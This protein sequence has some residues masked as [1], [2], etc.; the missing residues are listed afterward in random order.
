MHYHTLKQMKFKPSQNKTRL[1]WEHFGTL[2]CGLVVCLRVLLF[3]VIGPN[4]IKITE[5]F[6]VFLILLV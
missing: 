2:V 1:Q 5:I 6:Q 4:T 3:A